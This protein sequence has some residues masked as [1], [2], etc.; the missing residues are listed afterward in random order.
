MPTVRNFGI[1]NELGEAVKALCR[2]SRLERQMETFAIDYIFL[3]NSDRLRRGPQ[4]ASSIR[5]E[6]HQS[7]FRSKYIFIRVSHLK[8]QILATLLLR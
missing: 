8:F 1:T 7:C 6:K 4:P 3:V 2:L 5:K